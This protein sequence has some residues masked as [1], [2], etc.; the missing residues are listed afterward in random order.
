MD[1]CFTKAIEGF[2][3]YLICEDGRV[4]SLTRR[5]PCKGGT[6]VRK[7]RVLRPSSMK[8]KGYQKVTLRNRST[9]LVHRL[10]AEAFLPNPLNLPEVDHLDNN[11]KNCNLI[12]LEWV[13]TR[14]NSKRSYYRDK[15][16]LSKSVCKKGQ[17]GIAK[18]RIAQFSLEENF[19]KE[20]E[21]ARDVN[22]ELGISY[23]AISQCLKK[24]SKTSGGFIW[25]YV[26][27]Q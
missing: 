2:P 13:T 11:P 5:V 7:G 15:R 3:G 16:K 12:N 6:R 14:E 21:S 10:V 8:K 17:P 25:R 27:G 9:K 26:N 19:I 23:I 1:L 24:R 20:W 4:I 18:K 22:K